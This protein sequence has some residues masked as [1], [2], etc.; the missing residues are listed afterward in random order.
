MSLQEALSIQGDWWCWL[1]LVSMVLVP[2]NFPHS[3]GQAVMLQ[4]ICAFDFSDLP[5]WPTVIPTSMPRW[6]LPL[7]V[8]SAAPLI[9]LP[10]PTSIGVGMSRT[11]EWAISTSVALRLGCDTSH[12]DQDRR[13]WGWSRGL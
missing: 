5:V 7:R 4:G 10:Y 11:Q 9:A 3:R 2:A 6:V 12:L 1:H 13:L 8:L